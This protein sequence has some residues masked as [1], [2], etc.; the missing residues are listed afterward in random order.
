MEM[1]C[2][3]KRKDLRAQIKQIWINFQPLEVVVRG[4]DTQL[5]VSENLNKLTYHVKGW[6]D[7]ATLT[8]IE[9][10]LLDLCFNISICIFNLLSMYMQ[11][12]CNASPTMKIVA[13]V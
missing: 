6:A 13:V 10:R 9:T 11:Y 2:V 1:N 5:Q 12:R 3:S 7:I 4:S 8:L